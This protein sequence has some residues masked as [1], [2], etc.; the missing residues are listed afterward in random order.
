M[1]LPWRQRAAQT[2][3]ESSPKY[4]SLLFWIFIQYL[5]IVFVTTPQGYERVRRVSEDDGSTAPSYDDDDDDEE[6]GLD[7]VTNREVLPKEVREK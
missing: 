4:R 5:K 2:Q 7:E 3:S 6:E 1:A